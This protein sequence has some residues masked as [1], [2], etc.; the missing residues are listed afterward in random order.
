MPIQE[1]QPLHFVLSFITIYLSK[2]AIDPACSWRDV[3]RHHTKKW[4]SS[5]IIFHKI[6]QRMPMSLRCAKLYRISVTIMCIAIKVGASLKFPALTKFVCQFT[7]PPLTMDSMSKFQ[8]NWFKLLQ[9]IFSN[10]FFYSC[11]FTV[12][13]QLIG[14]VKLLS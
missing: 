5:K 14:V 4:R 9:N 6:K 8:W 2:I 10:T 11:S 13:L 1:D 7:K 3:N 12:I